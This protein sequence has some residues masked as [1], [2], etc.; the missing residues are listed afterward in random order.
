[1]NR[2]WGKPNYRGSSGYRASLRNAGNGQCSRK[3]VTDISDG[4]GALAKEGLVDPKGVCI[5]APATEVMPRWRASPSKGESIA[6]PFRWRESR[7]SEPS[8]SAAA[9]LLIHGKDD[10]VVPFVHSASMNATL[11]AA[12]KPVEFVQ[13]NGED[14]WLSREKTP[15]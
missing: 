4:V 9:I 14:H 5:V 15:V 7:T 11:T 2:W 6:A 12:G 8:C 13:L 1:M 10:P 3:M